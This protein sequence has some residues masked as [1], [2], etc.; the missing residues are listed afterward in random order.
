MGSLESP[1]FSVCVRVHVCWGQGVYVSVYACLHISVCPCVCI[2]YV[3]V[4]LHV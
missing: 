4:G 3:Y 2:V 1:S